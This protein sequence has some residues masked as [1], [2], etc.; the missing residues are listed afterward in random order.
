MHAQHVAHSGVEPANM[1]MQSAQR[2]SSYTLSEL[3]SARRLRRCKAGATGTEESDM[4]CK[5]VATGAE[6]SEM[7]MALQLTTVWLEHQ[8]YG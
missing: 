4:P 7:P 1:L 3:G 5:S 2:P 8:R 6:E